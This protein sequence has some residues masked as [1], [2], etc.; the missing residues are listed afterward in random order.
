MFIE[1]PLREKRAT[2]A[3][4]AEQAGE[5]Y[6]GEMASKSQDVQRWTVFSADLLQILYPKN[7]F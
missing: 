7:T 5:H 1:R 2:I 6:A 4:S 3:R